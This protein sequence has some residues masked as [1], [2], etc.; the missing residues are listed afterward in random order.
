MHAIVGPNGAGKSTLLNLISTRIKVAAPSIQVFGTDI[1][2]AQGRE[3]VRNSIGMLPQRFG[4]PGFMK[5][6]EFISHVAWLH[7]FS[8]EESATLAQSMVQKLGCGGFAGRRIRA[9]SGGQ[10]QRIAIAATAAF[11]P[12]LLIL[13]E[14]SVGL[15]VDARN[16]L[17]ETLME[18]AQEAV[19][20]VSTHNM[21]DIPHDSASLTVLVDGKVSFSDH[22]AR[23]VNAVPDVAVQPH[24]LEQAYS[25]LI[26]DTANVQ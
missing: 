18:L 16:Y 11:K 8:R 20:I 22:P 19:V 23:L 9:M 25:R 2:A 14:P 17:Q 12:K 3:K 15:D 10:R 26:R 6:T 21:S 7:G 24:E 4:T 1:S 5:G 13:D